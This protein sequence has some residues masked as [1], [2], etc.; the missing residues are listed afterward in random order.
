M[1]R[2]VRVNL[3]VDKEILEKA[4]ELGLNLSKTF[5]ICLKQRIEALPNLENKTMTNGGSN[6]DNSS[7][8]SSAPIAQRLER[9]FRKP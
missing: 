1:A 2:Q 3:T 5:E 6:E 7:H 8:R 4:K 9:R